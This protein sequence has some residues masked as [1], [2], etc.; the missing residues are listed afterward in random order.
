MRTSDWPLLRV[1]FIRFWF[2][3]AT[4]LLVTLKLAA[5]VAHWT[6]WLDGC[7]HHLNECGLAS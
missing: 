4:D 2:L 6:W 3:F 7:D 1:H 5:M